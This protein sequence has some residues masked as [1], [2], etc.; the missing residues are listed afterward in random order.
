MELLRFD[1]KEAEEYRALRIPEKVQSLIKGQDI[2]VGLVTGKR[3]HE[4]LIAE[5]GFAQGQD[6][7][8]IMVVED[9][10]GFNPTIQGRDYEQIPFPPDHVEKSFIK[11]MQE[12]RSLGIS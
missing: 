6:R 3:E 8:V 9:G 11:L 12:F 2:Y 5:A 4:W 10:A 7:H 1:V